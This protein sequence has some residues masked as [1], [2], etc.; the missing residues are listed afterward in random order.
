VSRVRFGI[1][2]D[3]TDYRPDP[4]NGVLIDYTI[5]ISTKYLG[6]DFS[7]FRHTFGVHGY[8]SPVRQFTFAA[9]IAYTTTSGSVPFSE[10]GTFSF[11]LGEQSGLGNETTLRGYQAQRF[12]G[13]TMTIGNL[14]VRWEFIEFRLFKQLFALKLIGFV[15]AGS[16]FNNPGEPFKVWSHYHIGYGPG[17]AIAWNQSIILRLYMGFSKEDM[18]IG[19]NFGHAF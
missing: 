8:Y 14:E 9:R 1:A 16:V 7:F 2:F 4:R 5:N 19:L 18:S 6:A 17:F 10:L 15:D 3:T 11:I 13:R 12:I